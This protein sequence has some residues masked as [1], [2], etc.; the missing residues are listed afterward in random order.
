MKIYSVHAFA[1]SSLIWRFM[2]TTEL[3]DESKGQ[4]QGILIA[5]PVLL[6]PAP[7][8]EVIGLWSTF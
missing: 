7:D 3:F 5:L 1:V 4:K 6:L 8:L 2:R